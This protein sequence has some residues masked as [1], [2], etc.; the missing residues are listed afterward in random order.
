VP[1]APLFFFFI[2]LYHN[3]TVFQSE[4]KGLFLLRHYD[5]LLEGE[6][7]QGLV[8]LIKLIAV[9]AAA[10]YLGRWFQAEMKMSKARKEPTYKPFLSLPGLLILGAII[11]LPIILW[12]LK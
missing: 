6:P 12:M 10:T 3:F 7:V 2:S 4:L 8:T 1:G 9:F 11:F 5:R